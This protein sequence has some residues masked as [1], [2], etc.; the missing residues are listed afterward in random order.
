MIGGVTAAVQ[1]AGI[2]VPG[3]YQFNVVVPE[4]LDG[5]YPFV[6]TIAGLTSQ[7]GLVLPVRR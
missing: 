7:S 4:L 3:E 2:V 6:A 1:F 5:D